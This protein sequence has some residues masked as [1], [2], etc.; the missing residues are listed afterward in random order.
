MASVV[1]ILS[2]AFLLATIISLSKC[3]FVRVRSISGTGDNAL[4]QVV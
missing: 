4:Q 3:L 1:F 2:D